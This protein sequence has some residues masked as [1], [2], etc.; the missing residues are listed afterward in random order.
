MREFHS[1]FNHA[2][3]P[4][5][6]GPSSSNTCGPVRI[7]LVCHQLLGETPAEA[8]VEYY[9][10]GAFPNTLYGMKSD[11]A[12][13]NG[14][15]GKEQNTPDFNDAYR[16]AEDA[17]MKITF[18]E[19]DDLTVG[20]M[21]TARVR[22]TARDGSTLT[23]IGESVGGGAFKIHDIDDCP[24][25]IQGTNHELLVFLRPSSLAAAERFCGKL[26]PQVRKLNDKYCV[27]G[28]AYDIVN[29][30]TAEAV[31]RELVE[32]ISADRCVLKVRTVAPVHPIV[33]DISR[34][35]PFETSE[36]MALYCRNKSCSPARAAIDYEMA[37]SGWD[38]ARVRR[39]GDML[40]SIMRNSQ[41]EGFNPELRFDGILTPKAHTLKDR[42]GRG[43]MPTLGLLD[44]AI[45]SAL[46]IMEYSNATGRI[47]CV[48]TGG[49]SGIVPGL[50]LAAAEKMDASDAEL[51]EA[52]MAAGIIGVLMMV[53]GNEFAGGTHG[54]QAEIAC[55]TAMASAGLAQLM[56]GT[57]KQA[58]DAASM[59]LQSFLGLICDPV[60][61]LVQ[62]P[63]LARNIA[64]VS[65]AAASAEAV[66]S[67]FDV[68]IPLD[69][70]SRIMVRVGTDITRELGM[71]CSG[72]C[73]TPTGKRLTVEHDNAVKCGANCSG[74]V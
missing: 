41:K 16:K 70:M 18:R 2:L 28:E 5:T 48:P 15:L 35:P 46:G 61:G 8:V 13:I 34:K 54:C 7:G 23:V 72:C 60:A 47:V 27:T 3:A 32:C 12:F 53:D 62:V 59:S 10:K 11:V 69:E 38:E 29:L 37:V 33:T 63:C 50:L 67:G 73:L 71:C 1:I 25:D 55:G 31:P 20:G 52:L 43:K 4:I 49:S 57:A 24:V 44:E 42:I 21:E 22:M 64:G 65:V 68:V 6:P 9:S 45:P 19:V 17:G 39:Y 66:C 74:Q 30:K 51:Y 26:V 40:I 14:L 36:E 58:C 56:G